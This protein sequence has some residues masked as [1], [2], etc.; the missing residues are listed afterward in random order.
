MMIF[1]REFSFKEWFFLLIL[2]LVWITSCSPKEIDE[3]DLNDPPYIYSSLEVEILLRVNS[4]RRS[5][6]LKE[7]DQLEEISRQALLHNG[8]MIR[9][10]EVCH[11]N[12]GGRY[13]V[14]VKQVGASAM[15]ENVGFGYRTS[16]AFVEAWVRSKGHR[17][18]LEK[19][20]SHFGISAAAG[21]DEKVYVTLI[22]VRK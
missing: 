22:F 16:G 5:K 4:Y 11:H 19:Q 6:G 14:L 18:I 7:L 10:N 21:D 17:E 8:H 9:A 12:F 3:L 2:L 1:E 15:A 20:H 13:R